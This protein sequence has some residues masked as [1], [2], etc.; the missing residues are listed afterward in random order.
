MVPGLIEATRQDLDYLDQL[1]VLAAMAS[2]P[3]VL[4]AVREDLREMGGAEGEQQPK[5]GKQGDKRATQAKTKGGGK[6]KPGVTPLRIRATDGTEILVG[7][8]ARQND[9]VTFQL[10]DPRDI[11]F[12][13]RQ[14]PR[15]HVICA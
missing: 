11:W 2:D 13:A 4:A 7:R 14:I 5:G 3:A 1:A 8:S 15:A 12:H 10:A 6:G 9:A